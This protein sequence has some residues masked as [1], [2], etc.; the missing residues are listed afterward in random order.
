M[1]TCILTILIFAYSS[2]QAF[3]PDSQ[4]EQQILDCMQSS[5]FC[6][7]LVKYT[8]GDSTYDITVIHNPQNEML[9][10]AGLSEPV[11][12]PLIIVANLPYN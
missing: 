10:R 11:S 7:E 2:V 5:E 12:R 8:F 9:W 4:A 6:N 1:K 3:V